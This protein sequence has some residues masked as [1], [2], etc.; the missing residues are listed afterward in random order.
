MIAYADGLQAQEFHRSDAEL[1]LRLGWRGEFR[2]SKLSQRSRDAYWDSLLNAIPS[3]HAVIWDKSTAPEAQFPGANPEIEMMRKAM[4][5]LGAPRPTSRLIVD[6]VHH[7]NR[8]ADIRRALGVSEVRFEHS[9]ANPHL[10]LADM[11]AGF[12]AWD[13]AQRLKDLNPA[14]RSLKRFRSSWR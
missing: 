8:A 4:S 9:H 12:H 2:W 10:Q 14:L 1:R 7:R 11:L 5:S 6:G 3:H 13:H